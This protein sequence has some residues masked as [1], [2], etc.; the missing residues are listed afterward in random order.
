MRILDLTFKDLAQLARDRRSLLFLVA[1]PLVFTLFMGF[2]MRSAAQPADP[3]LALGWV[4]QDPDGLLSEQLFAS[5]SASEALRLVPTDAA[6]A[7]DSVAKGQ[8]AGVLVVPANFSAD[9]LAGRPTQL[10]L[11]TDPLSTRG[12]SLGRC[13]GWPSLG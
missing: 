10:S 1:M 11:I 8:L 9:A 4:T 7:S 6:R 12:Q 5:L 2:A 3:R 13:C